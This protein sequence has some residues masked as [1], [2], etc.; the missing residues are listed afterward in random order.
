M[1]THLLPR[2]V[3]SITLMCVCLAARAEDRRFPFAFRDVTTSTGLLPDV[4]GIR[5][6]GAAWGDVDGDGNIDLYVGTFGNQGS[7]DNLFFRNKGGKFELDGEKNLRI[8]T[9]A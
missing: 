1:T 9:R 8:T 7:K 2:V 3:L 5:G 6:H 4:G